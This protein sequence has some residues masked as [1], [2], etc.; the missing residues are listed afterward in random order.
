M[1]AR[2]LP[3]GVWERAVNLLRRWTL[4]CSALHTGRPCMEL[5][6]RCSLDILGAHCPMGIDC[7]SC[8]RLSRPLEKCYVCC[9]AH[10]LSHTIPS[11]SLQTWG[12]PVWTFSWDV[13]R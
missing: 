5:P 12:K 11:L 6:A 1:L 2:C 13:V 10:I 9:V 8:W 3:V 4:Q 7:L